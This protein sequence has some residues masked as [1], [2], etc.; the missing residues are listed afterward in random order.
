ML[1]CDMLPYKL[2][3]SYSTEARA[4]DSVIHRAA[5]QLHPLHASLDSRAVAATLSP[6]QIRHGRRE[7]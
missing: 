4:F 3:P 2:V 7:H 6:H 1:A 5:L